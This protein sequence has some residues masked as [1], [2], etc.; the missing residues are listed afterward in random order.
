M[1]RARCWARFGG[2]PIPW[3]DDIDV[4]VPRPDY[5][6][7]VEEFS[8]E[9]EFALLSPGEGYPWNFSKLVSLRTG[10]EEDGLVM[11]GRMGVFVDVFPVDGLPS[12]GYEERVAELRPAVR[13]AG[14]VF[15]LD[16]SSDAHRGGIKNSL[17]CV[18]SAVGKH[19]FSQDELARKIQDV[20]RR[21]F[22]ESSEKVGVLFGAYGAPREEYP[23]S[24]FDGFS[25]VRFSGRTFKTFADPENYLTHMYGE[26]WRVPT[27]QDPRVHGTAYFLEEGDIR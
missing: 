12:G 15:A 18:I 24:M 9:A 17:R 6:R 8:D 21:S 13:L 19:A 22:F 11:P 10:F 4:L 26:D 7:F 3:D 14:I 20:C 27:P 2:G 25:E 16:Y 5:D 1:Q 23:R